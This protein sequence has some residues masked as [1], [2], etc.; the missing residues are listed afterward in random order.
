M[1]AALSL[2]STDQLNTFVL[3]LVQN[4]YWMLYSHFDGLATLL[5]NFVHSLHFAAGILG[6]T[7]NISIL[8]LGSVVLRMV[9][10]RLH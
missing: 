6:Y 3:Q 7:G 9:S 5:I 1:Y 4:G 8:F 2:C 10:R